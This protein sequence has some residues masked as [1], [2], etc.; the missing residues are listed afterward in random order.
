M[1]GIDRLIRCNDGDV[2]TEVNALIPEAD[3]IMV[4][5]N[6]PVYGGSG[7]FTYATSYTEGET[8]E[9]VASHELGHSLIG[10]WDEYD[11]GYDA[12]YNGG[13]NCS[14]E[15]DGSSWAHWLGQRRSRCLRHLL[16]PGSVS[17]HSK[18]LHDEF[19][20]GQLLSR[21]S[22]THRSRHLRSLAQFVCRYFRA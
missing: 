15:G 10:L 11:Y 5:V 13:P 7:G 3:G 4:L 20:T 1:Q 17:A 6:D 14:A 16:L 21:V 9:M 12:G 2:V 18:R 22:R 8:G 19:A